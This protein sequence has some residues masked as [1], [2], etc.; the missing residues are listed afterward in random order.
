LN[1]YSPCKTNTDCGGGNFICA[2][3]FC[4]V[5]CSGQIAGPY[6]PCAPAPNN[7][8]TEHCTYIDSLSCV[9]GQPC[10]STADGPS[11][12]ALACTPASNCPYGT[13]CQNGYCR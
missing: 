1:M 13:T 3:G 6:P 11:Y 12:C 4:T 9:P 8:V 5:V 7:T 2:F 10:C